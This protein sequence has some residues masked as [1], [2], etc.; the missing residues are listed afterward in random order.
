MDRIIFHVDMDAFYAS[1]EEN[2]NPLLKK[3]PIVVA[4]SSNRGVVTT[5]N[6]NARKFG[7]HSAMPVFMAKKLCP[8]LVIVPVRMNRYKEISQMI[9]NILKKYTDSVEMVSLDEAYLDLTG[10]TQDKER[11][12]LDIQAKVLN[13]TNLTLS[14]GISYNKYLAKIASDWNKP[15]GIKIIDA[16]MMPEI[17]FDLELNK[18]HGLG[19]VSISRFN[20]IGIYTVEDLYAL[21]EEFLIDFLGSHGSEIYNR[22]RGIDLR[23]VTPYRE[24]KSIGTEKTFKNDISN[25]DSLMEILDLFAREISDSLVDKNFIAK[26]LTVKLKDSNFKSKSKSI[27]L[28]E[29]TDDYDTII[30]RSKILL[31]ELFEE[32]EYRLMGLTASSLIE[33]KFKQLSLF[34]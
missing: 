27:T 32:K 22:I 19:N 1:V 23:E 25:L 3:Y 29:Y 30:F 16:S 33:N 18:V 34:D 26:T 15:N 20:N 8:N 13:E 21:S 4:G 6:Y 12:A 31:N 10:L 7:L 14:I 9:F 17:L 5:A 28:T 24:R 11:T 2:D